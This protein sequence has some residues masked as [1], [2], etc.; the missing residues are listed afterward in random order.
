[1]KLNDTVDRELGSGLLCNLNLNLVQYIH[2]SLETAG[3]ASE[4][5]EDRLCC[6]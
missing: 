4:A 2:T 6:H 3:S 5:L 1:M